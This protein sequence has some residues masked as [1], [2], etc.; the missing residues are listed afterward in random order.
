MCIILGKT[1]DPC[2]TMKLSTLLVAIYSSEFGQPDWQVFVGTR[3]KLV[4]LTVVRTVHR[5]EQ[6]LF[7]FLRRIDG[8]ET[9]FSILG[10]VSRSNPQI[11]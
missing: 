2:K 7:S 8:L 3:F 4:Y 11:L 5:F 1:P 10:I 9:V 6:K